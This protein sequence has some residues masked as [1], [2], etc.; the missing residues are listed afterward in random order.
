[1]FLASTNTQSEDLVSCKVFLNDPRRFQ[2]M[3][4]A[5][6]EFVPT[7]DPPARATVRANL[8]NVL[9]STEIQCVAVDSGTRSVVNAQARGR[10][11]FSPG[12]DVG[13]RVYVAG[14]TGRGATAAEETSSAL[15]RIRATLSAASL[16]FDDLEE[17]WVYLADV[18]DWESVHE[19]L[20]EEFGADYPAPTVVGNRLVGRSTVEIQVTAR[21]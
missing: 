11:P 13:D 18:R 3:N 20:V 15:E 16:D 2:E 14:A 6:A 5:Y 19:V 10:S 8:V 9:F 21:R 7:D 1:M 17:V 12:I 4:G